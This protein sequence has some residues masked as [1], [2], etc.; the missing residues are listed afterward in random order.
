MEIIKGGWAFDRTAYSLPIMKYLVNEIE[1]RRSTVV[2]PED[3]E[4]GMRFKDTH[5]IVVRVTSNYSEEEFMACPGL[6]IDSMLIDAA[7]ADFWYN[8]KKQYEDHEEYQ[9]ENEDE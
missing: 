7:R 5:C 6:V 4:I 8:H 2:L 9:E 1:N 3:T